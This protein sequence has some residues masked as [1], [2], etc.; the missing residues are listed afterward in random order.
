[1]EGLE[2]AI[3]IIENEIIKRES[4]REN[5]EYLLRRK[6]LT[7]EVKS[8]YKALDLV[9][10]NGV[11][12]GVIVCEHKQHWRT[13]QEDGSVKKVCCNCNKGISEL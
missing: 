8:L 10:N 9:K 5:P 4:Q 12:D 1:M 2:R 11:L 7:E 6:L 3:K 13:L